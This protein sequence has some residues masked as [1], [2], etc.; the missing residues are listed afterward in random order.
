MGLPILLTIF[1][2]FFLN[3]GYN[4][5]TATGLPGFSMLS[6]FL[7]SLQWFFPLVV[8]LSFTN[9]IVS[10]ILLIAIHKI[11]TRKVIKKYLIYSLVSMVIGL[12]CFIL[13]SASIQCLGCGGSA[14]F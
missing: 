11:D 13:I 1:A 12:T 5:L 3:G 10:L 4:H 2:Y 6:T 8:I 14:S 7:V 9:I